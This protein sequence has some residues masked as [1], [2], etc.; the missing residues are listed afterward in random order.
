MAPATDPTST[1]GACDVS[2][3]VNFHQGVTHEGGIP[4]N[5]NLH[6]N[7][8]LLRALN[9]WQPRFVDWWR[10]LGPAVYSDKYVYLR[11]ATSVG[12]EG[13]AT[14]DYVRLPEYRWGIFLA[15]P[16][17]NRA[18]AFGQ[19]Q[20]QPAWQEVPGEYRSDLQRLIVV[21]GDT[22]PASV[23]QQRLLGDTAPSLYD[24]RSLFQ[25][26]V[27]EGRHLWAMVYLLHA[28][29]GR[30]GRDEADALLERHSG[31]IDRPRILEAFNS[32]TADWLSMFMFAYFTDRD[33]KFQL[34][35]LR[36]SAFDPL[37]R[38]SSFMLKEESYHMSVGNNGLHRIIQRAAELMLEF[39]DAD[40]R[41]HGGIDLATIQKYLNLYCS[42]SLDLFGNE[43]STNAANY[44][45]QGLK[46]RY[47]EERREDDH[48][49]HES[50][51]KIEI[52]V[53]SHVES[54]EVPAL[55][56]LNH[57]LRSDY[58]DDCQRGVD[59]W[60]RGLEGAGIE[61]RFTLPHP[62]FNR[63]VGVFSGHHLTPDGKPVSAEEWQQKSH[64][65]LPTKDDRDFVCSLMKGVFE[66]GKVAGWIAP[67]TQPINGQPLDFDY[68]KL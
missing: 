22:E 61:F 60:N 4:N 48:R 68:V 16:E 33:G 32:D 2:G 65:W 41:K 56:A 55:Q 67:P 28:H 20:G 1:G 13:W 14:W 11:T 52:P 25:V 6:D 29:F 49:L 47:Q 30:E 46:G 26:N 5:I 59:T 38:T 7:P 10:D 34:S 18:I 42:M 63:Q 64:H 50:T 66:R 54:V 3:E 40:I 21:Q 23:E 27:E 53:N 39:D 44:F 58:L 57:S 12:R 8:K 31:S 36:E 43:K 9:S 37:S 24:L 35:A 19:H 45:A 17:A 62:G 51:L 15:A